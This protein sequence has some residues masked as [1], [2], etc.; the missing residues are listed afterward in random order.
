M[1]QPLSEIRKQI[2]AL[3]AEILELFNRRA[4]LAQEV[5]EAKLAA[6]ETDNFYRPEREAQVLQRVR[7]LN[8]GPLDD[9]S[10]ARL[11]R[12]LMSACLALEKPLTVAF[13]GPAGTF[14]QQAA[15]KHFGHAVQA[16]PLPAIDEIFRAVESGDCQF[17]VVPVENST[18][19]VITHT[20]D[21]FLNS[22]LGICGEV[23]LRIHHNLMGKQADLAAIRKVFSHQQS[24][25]Q[26]RRWLDRYLPGA[27]RVAVSSNAEAA[28]LAAET[29]DSAAVA[30]ETAADIYG[31]AVLQRNIEDEA[32][33]TTRF[34]VIGRL[35]VGP[36]GRDK[37]SLLISTGN[38]P[39]ALHRALAPFAQHGISMSKIESRPSRRGAWDYVFF[40][41]V[42]GHRDD[43]G[44]AEALRVAQAEVSFVKV[45]GSYPR[46]Q[47]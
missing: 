10:V 29:P 11:F 9:D 26:C 2:D 46:A 1:T 43:A 25:A 23:S 17:G 8:Q 22:S 35:A 13:L 16:V 34:L 33:N 20:L 3:D 12:E 40:I 32:D 42:E 45:L 38:Q 19:G 47:A 36:T 41:D 7:D 21:S 28:R 30:G 31:L 44:V 4:R 5:A 27:E 37:T 6:G 15:Y 24:L 14:S 18:E 39:G